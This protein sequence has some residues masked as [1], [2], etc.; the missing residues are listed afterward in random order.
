M[1]KIIGMYVNHACLLFSAYRAFGLEALCKTR[2]ATRDT[3]YA[4]VVIFLPY[5]GNG[6]S[7]MAGMFPLWYA[8]R[9]TARG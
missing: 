5:M 4:L 1:I 3:I 2:Y 6:S 7:S 9:P 8:V